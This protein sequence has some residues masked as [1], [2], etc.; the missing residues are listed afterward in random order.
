MKRQASERDDGDE[1]WPS[2]NEEEEDKYDAADAFSPADVISTTHSGVSIG[3][4]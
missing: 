4:T 3:S 1:G 2:E